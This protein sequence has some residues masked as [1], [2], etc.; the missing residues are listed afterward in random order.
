MSTPLAVMPTRPQASQ[1]TGTEAS[2]Q[3]RA[4]DTMGPPAAGDCS[5]THGA[6]LAENPGEGPL[7]DVDRGALD[8]EGG[9]VLF[10]DLAALPGA[11][12]V[13]LKAGPELRAQLGP[14]NLGRARDL[15]I[16]AMVMA[17]QLIYTHEGQTWFDTVLRREG[18]FE[19]VRMAR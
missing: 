2:C 17:V 19:V 15:L 10:D 16:D 8:A 3:G 6:T 11:V 9:R 14:I 4:R 7:P 18:A 1:V 13:R 12:E 5:S